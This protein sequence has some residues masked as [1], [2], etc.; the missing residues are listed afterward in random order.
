M[1]LSDEEVI[2]YADGIG[3]HWYTD[4]FTLA[5]FLNLATNNVA[6]SSKELFRLA[7]EACNG[8]YLHIMH[9]YGC[10]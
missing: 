5:S 2:N 9:S 7:T 10:N 4:D 1:V 8:M 6:D 3:L